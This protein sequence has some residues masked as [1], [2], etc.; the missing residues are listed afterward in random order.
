E[1]E[2]Q[3]GDEKEFQEGE[4]T[5]CQCCFGSYMAPRI[6]KCPGDHS[7]CDTCIRGHAGTQLGLQKTDIL[8]MYPGDVDCQMAFTVSTLEKCLPEPLLALY[9]RLKQQ[10]ALKVA[11]IEG[12]EECPFCSFACIMDMPLQEVPIFTCQ[13]AGRCGAVSCRICRA[14]AHP[15]RSCDRLGDAGVHDGRLALEEAM[16]KALM[17][18]CPRCD[19]P[20]IKEDGCNKMTC[21]QCEALSCYV[22]RRA[23]DDYEHF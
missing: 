2:R 4:E 21:P 5:E 12:L 17:R 3:E 1:T 7:F 16:S 20:F 11:N 10:E 13:D 9:H 18:T 19:A 14:K 8:C 22:C 23:I 15:G 6:F